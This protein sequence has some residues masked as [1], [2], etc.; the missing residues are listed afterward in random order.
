MTQALYNISDDKNIQFKNE[1]KKTHSEPSTILM[2]RLGNTYKVYQEDAT[3]CAEKL[4]RNTENGNLEFSHNMLDVYL[5]KLIRLGYR[6]AIVDG[7]Y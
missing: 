2:F 6:V 4:C 1:F 7:Q 3:K 5:P